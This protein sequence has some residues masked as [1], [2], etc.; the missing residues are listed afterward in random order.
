M[1][2]DDDDEKCIQGEESS[3]C[4]DMK[5]FMRR[6]FETTSNQAAVLSRDNRVGENRRRVCEI[7]TS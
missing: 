5:G 6:A 4:S 7:W 3:A 1:I 2:A